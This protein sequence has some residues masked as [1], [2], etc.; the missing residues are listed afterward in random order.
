MTRRIEILDTTLRD[1][2]KL[3]F[4][5]LSTA[6]RIALARQLARLGVDVIEAGFPAASAEEAECVARVG[7]EVRGPRVAALARALPADVDK[8]LEAL[9]G[10]EKKHLHLFMSVSPQFLAQVLRQTEA[11]ALASIGSLVKTGKSAGVRVQF[12]LSE[13]PHARGEFLLDACRA[14]REAGAD[15]L[16]IAD[17]NGILVPADVA[18]LVGRVRAMLD[19][20]EGRGAADRRPLPQRPRP[21]HRQ[22]P[23]RDP[24]PAP[25]TWR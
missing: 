3:P 21:G 22:H 11:Q 14:A 5:V 2:N 4:V 17:T 23:R 9:S 6:E 18:E 25:R 1:G 20:R 24:R 16:N 15:V 13:A 8:A 10:A 7:R 12:S 19:R